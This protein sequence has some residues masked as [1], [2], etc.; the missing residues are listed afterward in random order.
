MIYPK[1]HPSIADKHGVFVGHFYVNESG[2]LVRIYK[3]ILRTKSRKCAKCS[4][5]RNKM[6]NKFK[7]KAKGGSMDNFAAWAFFAA[8]AS[9]SD[10]G[11][12]SKELADKYQS[13]NGLDVRIVV[14]GKEHPFEELMDRLEEEFKRLLRDEAG[15]VVEG[16]IYEM[17]QLF[18]VLMKKSDFDIERIKDIIERGSDDK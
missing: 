12:V 9:M 2:T 15:K 11:V 4:R 10:G 17:G 6:D 3:P 5:R 7:Y 8:I 18:T 13:E 16:R 14:D 1:Q